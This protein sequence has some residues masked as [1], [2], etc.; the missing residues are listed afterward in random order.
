MR[1]ESTRPRSVVTTRYLQTIDLFQFIESCKF[2]V[3]S[4]AYSELPALILNTDY[5]LARNT[6][7]PSVTVALR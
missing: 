7:T 5:V 2:Q 3:S 6:S 1:T 4:V